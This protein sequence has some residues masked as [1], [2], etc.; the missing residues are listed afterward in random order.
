VSAEIIW[1]DL[2]CGS[3]SEDLPLWRSLASEFGDPILDVGAGT[4][5]VALEL[6]RAGHRVTALDSDATLLAEL[7]S[8]A[9]GLEQLDTVLAD[10]RSFA[11]GRTFALCLVPMQTIQLLGGATARAAFLRCAGAHLR[12]GGLLAVAIADALEPYETDGGGPAPLPDMCE[13]DGIV[14]SSFPTAIREDGD[15]FVIERRRETVDVRGEHSIGANE[16]RLD[17]VSPSELEREGALA[18]LDPAPRARVPATEDY[19]G[20]EVVM[21]RA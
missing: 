12:R 9:A 14:Y 18:G 3:Y 1:H 6:A 19:V 15:G 10:A 21:L 11:L 13:R 8:R 17:R 5:R 7:E 16:I 4:G 20:S 2:E